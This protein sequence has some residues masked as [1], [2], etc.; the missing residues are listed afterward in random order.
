[1]SIITISSIITNRSTVATRGR[2]EA[3]CSTDYVIIPHGFSS[4]GDGIQT[5]DRFCG[6]ALNDRVAAGLPAASVP[7]T[8]M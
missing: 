6:Q 8:S 7:I 5:F 1:M 2:G 4:L 3:F